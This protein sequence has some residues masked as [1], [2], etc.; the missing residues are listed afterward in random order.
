MRFS[1]APRFG[2]NMAL[3][4]FIREVLLPDAALEL[5]S[6]EFTVSAFR[7]VV[8]V[9]FDLTERPKLCVEVLLQGDEGC[10]GGE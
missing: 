9:A 8:V 3:I 5:V 6:G 7:F 4:F 2:W 10:F 1:T